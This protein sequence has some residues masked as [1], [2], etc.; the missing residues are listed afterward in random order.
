LAFLV[1]GAVG[2][3]TLAAFSAISAIYSACKLPPSALQGG[4]MDD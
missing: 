1:A 4:D 2:H 3:V